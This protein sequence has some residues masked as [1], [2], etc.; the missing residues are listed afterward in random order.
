MKQEAAM[1]SNQGKVTGIPISKI[2]CCG[3]S[4]NWIN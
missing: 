3:D 2:S 1:S 4:G